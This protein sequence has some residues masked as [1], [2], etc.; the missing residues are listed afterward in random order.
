MWSEGLSER[1]HLRS[2]IVPNMTDDEVSLE[3]KR[4]RAK[5]RLIR[6]KKD[7]TRPSPPGGF[8]IPHVLVIDYI[9][10]T[11]ECATLLRERCSV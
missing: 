3:L 11:E 6:V 7:L 2:V 10:H 8:S 9:R 4:T 5:R 1:N